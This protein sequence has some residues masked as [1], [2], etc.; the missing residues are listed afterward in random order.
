MVFF[1]NFCLCNLN[2]VGI[3]VQKISWFLFKSNML[4]EVDGWIVEVIKDNGLVYCDGIVIIEG[5]GLIEV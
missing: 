2:F 5:D 4:V 1:E 3:I